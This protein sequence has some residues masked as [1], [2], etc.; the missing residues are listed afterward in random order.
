MTVGV[1]GAGISGL[2]LVHA[3]ADEDE[4][5]VAFEAR[6]EPGGVMRSRR[7]DGRV[8]ELGP[9]RL[10]LT[11]GLES[12]IDDLGLRDQL[13]TGDDDQPL[14]VYHD[15]SL[16]VV[17]LSLRE[18][19][20]TDLL[21]PLGKLRILKEPLTDSARPGETVE[22]YLV[23][24]FGH[25][26]AHRFL[27][28]L[29]SGLYGTAPEN[30]LMEY[31]LGR[32]LENAGIDG[33]VLLWVARKLLSGRETPPICTFDD[34]LGE[35]TTGLYEAH[36]ETIALD[37]PVERIDDAGDGYELVTDEGTERVDDVVLT[38]PAPTSADL[39][40]SVDADL[41]ATLR[42]FNYNPI[43][44]V[45]VES[46]LERDGIGALVPSG[47]DIGISGSTWNASF[48]D[49]D[50]VFTCYVDPGS[51]PEMTDR[52]DEELGE[53]AAAEFERLTG[54]AASPI[55]VHRWNPGMP[56]YDR[57]WTAMDDLEAPDGLH[58]CANYVG[59]PGIPGRLRNAKRLAGE[60]SDD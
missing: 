53:V 33:S 21:S 15:G 16:E 22:E 4:D 8:L 28:P 13:R 20:T 26:A 23:R 35:L 29:Y 34:G 55:H 32:A 37:T 24:K 46:D 48:L 11:P 3:L 44:M 45:F 6:D 60:L 43:G 41:A 49:R 57:S 59:R 54:A 47:A 56:A 30:M 9:Q 38:T 58:F 17:P 1:V 25:Q 5:V 31:S 18:A 52:S 2:S 40:E 39:L 27:G 42:K 10:R 14:Y 12:M 36:A 50:R 51:D 7:V 19:I